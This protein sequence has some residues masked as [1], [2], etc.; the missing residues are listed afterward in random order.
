M[1]TSVSQPIDPREGEP[2]RP[3]RVL[4]ADDHPLMRSSVRR[5]VE[6]QGWSICAEASTGREAVEL[7]ARLQPDVAVLDI[8]MPEL[9]GIDATLQLKKRAPKCE[10]LIFTGIEMRETVHRG[11]E[12]GA[13]SYL[14]KTDAGEHLVAALRALAQHKAYFTPD[15]AEIVFERYS[16]PGSKVEEVGESALTLREREVIQLLAEGCS[17][18]EVAEKL[19]VSLKTAETHRAS[20][21]RK[22][23]CHAFA[24]LVRYAIR[25]GM[26][27]A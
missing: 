1:S 4:V 13:R 23:R 8:H 20:I 22:L 3:L 24:D 12:A 19:G 25:S 9:N 14:L 18:K 11:I 21:M 27:Q 6:S 7:A 16:S 15:V 5:L 2:A 10:V 17:N 26:I